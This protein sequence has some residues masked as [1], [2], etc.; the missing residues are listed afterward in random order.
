MNKNEFQLQ[1]KSTAHFDFLPIDVDGFHWKIH[2]DCIAMPLFILACF[3]SLNDARFTCPTIA[4]QH[5]F[6]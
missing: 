6:E 2:T 4:N 1:R 5:N 3:E